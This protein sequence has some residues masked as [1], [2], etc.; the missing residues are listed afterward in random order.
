MCTAG[1]T[2]DTS[3]AT[4]NGDSE[5]IH[6]M[7][8][9][10]VAAAEGLNRGDLPG[11]VQRILDELVKPSVSWKD[12]I[13]SKASAIFGKGRYVWKRPGRRSQAT[14]VRFP[15]RNP[16]NVGALVW[17]DTSG[18]I[19]EACFKQFASECYGILTQTGCDSI[20]IGCH[21]VYA[22]SLTE[23]KSKDDIKKI[24]Y[25]GGGT[26]HLDVFDVVN[27]KV[28]QEGIELPKGYQVGMVICLSDMMSEFPDSCQYETVWGVPSKYYH[29]NRENGWGKVNFGREIEV[30]IDAHK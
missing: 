25:R 13:R 7:N 15:S 17:I 14:G 23:V 16:E 6:K 4:E 10:V 9:S 22:Y 29:R 1:V 24:E 8:R 12:L 11:A 27:G 3:Q 5:E 19:S 2:S 21:D 26:S 28:G 18:S 30:T 20:L